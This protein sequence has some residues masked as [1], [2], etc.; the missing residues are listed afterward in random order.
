MFTHSVSL[1]RVLLPRQTRT[2]SV[3]QVDSTGLHLELDD[4]RTGPSVVDLFEKKKKG[5][6][7]SE[8]GELDELTSG[9]RVDPSV[10]AAFE[11]LA[12]AVR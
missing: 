11:T 10:N 7:R 8:R 3:F 5:G 2:A 6:R 1:E 12:S 9:S 4:E